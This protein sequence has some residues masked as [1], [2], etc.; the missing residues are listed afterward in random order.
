MPDRVTRH[1]AAP[2]EVTADRT[3]PNGA[4]ERDYSDGGRY[5][6]RVRVVGGVA[7]VNASTTLR[8]VTQTVEVPPQP[9]EAEF[10]ALA[11]RS[12]GVV[13]EQALWKADNYAAHWEMWARAWCRAALAQRRK[14]NRFVGLVI[15]GR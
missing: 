15:R 13:A 9:T 1:R 14:R 8:G 6:Y 4:V 3:L 5:S 7:Q 2:I 10:R 12:E 11:A